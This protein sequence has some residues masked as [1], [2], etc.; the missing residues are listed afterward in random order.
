MIMAKGSLKTL[1]TAFKRGSE[2]LSLLFE[3]AFTRTL[4]S[5]ITMITQVIADPCPS[6]LKTQS[7]ADPLAIIIGKTQ[8]IVVRGLPSLACSH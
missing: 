4:M 8:V 6:A 1:Q 7:M 2:N 5:I 3:N